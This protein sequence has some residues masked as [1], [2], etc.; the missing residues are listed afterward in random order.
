MDWMHDIA[1]LRTH[2]SVWGPSRALLVLAACLGFGALTG[3]ARGAEKEVDFKKEIQPIFKASCVKCHSLNNPRKQAAS[4]LRLDDKTAALVGG[5]AGNDIVPGKADDSLLYKL[6]KGPVS[7]GGDDIDAMPKPM[8]GQKW[9]P[10][11]PKQ[12]ELIKQWLDQG[13]KWPD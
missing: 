2:R 11:P 1:G 3:A 10:L 5:K 6:L 13:A 4:G 7:E 12:V 8:R 9:K